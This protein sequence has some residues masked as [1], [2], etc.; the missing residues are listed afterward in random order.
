MT[1]DLLRRTGEALYGE[2]WQSALAR[3]LGVSDRRVRAWAAGEGQPHPERW[4]DMRRL[5]EQ[6]SDQLDALAGDY[7]LL[8][9]EL[10]RR[11]IR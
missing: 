9:P 1:T 5:V 8:G 2:R 6:R 4:Q 7:D 10:S 11:P 3:A